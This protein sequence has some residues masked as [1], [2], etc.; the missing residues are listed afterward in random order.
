MSEGLVVFD[1]RGN[2][3]LVNS[4]AARIHGFASPESMKRS[5]AFFA[6]R[7]ELT[8][9]DGQ[10]VSLDQWPVSRVLRGESLTNWELRAR[11]R[12]TGHEGYFSF[13]G[14]PVRN[15]R[16]RQILAVIHTRDVSDRKEAELVLQEADRRK[17]DFL[18]V[19][20]HE[21]RNPLTPIR[22]SLYVLDHTVPG[23]EQA[24][25]AQAV[26]KRQVG[27]LSRLVDDLLDVTRISRGK[28]WLQR[29]PL[30]LNDLV[31]RMLEDHR[32][33][34]DETGIR[35]EIAL[36]PGVLAVNGDEQRLAQVVGNLLQNSAKFTGPGGTTRVSTE[37]TQGQAVL[38]VVDTGVGM[39]A[40]MLSHLFEPFTQAEGTQDRSRGGLGLGLALV[41]GLVELHGGEVSAHSDGVGQGTALVV[42]LP[43]SS[44]PLSVPEVA[45][46]TSPGARQRV[47][48]I[49]DN[50]DAAE[51]LR[52]A[53]QLADHD[54]VVARSGPEGLEKARTYRP[55]VLLC[56]IGLPGMSGYEVASAFRADES[57]RGTLLVA[58]SGYALPEDLHR[59]A[60]AGFSLHLA[61]PASLEKL[62]EL[63]SSLPPPPP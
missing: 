20:S 49:E 1:M 60:R 58:V 47:L 17:T 22:N 23:S 52:E 50:A 40:Q 51:S 10:L 39:D 8:E 62:E 37:V 28:I 12:E 15:E 46:V 57:L 43:L 34:F 36:A 7:F 13:S 30:D 44:R 6:Q 26:I 24:R 59:A 29:G 3:V 31:R 38:R 18:A 53:L 45:P 11:N 14:E 55:T 19:L 27:Q 5:V 32:S 4:A 35:L 61:K 2:A 33:L 42:R 48:V 54:V 63:L 56:D 9:L 16:G 21:L 41:R 25:R